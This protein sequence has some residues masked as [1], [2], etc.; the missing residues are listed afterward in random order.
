M[1]HPRPTVFGSSSSLVRPIAHPTPPP[2]SAPPP[3]PMAVYSFCSGVH[4]EHDETVKRTTQATAPIHFFD[5]YT[6]T[7]PQVRARC[8]NLNSANFGIFERLGL[9]SRRTCHIAR[10]S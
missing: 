3:A 6:K 4:D 1:P 9:L 7:P 8:R 2:T 10:D 5:R